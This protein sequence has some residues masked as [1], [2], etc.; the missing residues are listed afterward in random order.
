MISIGT[1]RQELSK[2]IIS[3]EMIING[4]SVLCWVELKK[5]KDLWTH[6]HMKFMYFCC[7]Q[8]ICPHNV[9]AH[10]YVPT[11][12]FFPSILKNRQNIAVYF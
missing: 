10:V 2:F 3:V 9:C 6:S 5:R 11:Y 4:S 1:E 7:I 12:I 8:L